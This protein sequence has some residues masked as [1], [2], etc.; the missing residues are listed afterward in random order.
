MHWSNDR[1]LQLFEKRQRLW[2]RFLDTYLSGEDGAERA[3]CR[4][5]G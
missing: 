1:L 3:L 2:E 5:V 4:R